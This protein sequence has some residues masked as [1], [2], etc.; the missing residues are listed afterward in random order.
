M[1]NLTLQ[2]KAHDSQL[3]MAGRVAALLRERPNTWIDG[4]EFSRI[5]GY[6]GWRT[7]ISNVRRRP[8]LM[9]VRNRQ[10]PVHVDDH[11]ITIS[12]YMYEPE[13]RTAEGAAD[14]APTSPAAA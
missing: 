1:E 11:T 13:K 4:R 10:R 7:R 14:D 12:E 5:A 9:R 2:F 3:T 8:Y 6:A